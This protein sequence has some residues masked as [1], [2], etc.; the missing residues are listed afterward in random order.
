QGRPLASELRAEPRDG[1]NRKLVAVLAREGADVRGMR[2][3]RSERDV[4]LVPEKLRVRA[5]E[6]EHSPGQVK[7]CAA[8]LDVL[9]QRAGRI[10]PASLFQLGE[11]PS[12][13]GVIDRPPVIG[14]DEREFPQLVS[15]VDVGYSGRSELE[16][17]L[18]E[19]V[20]EAERRKAACERGH[21]VRERIAFASLQTAANELA[22]ARF[23]F[24][25]G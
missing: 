7:F 20:D 8:V 6:L 21:L 1:G 15:L 11:Q 9:E 16:Q 19:P 4:F 17:G 13:Q 25:V 22:Q 2:P 14:I 12:S 23:V 5:A 10:R 3:D 24:L 18:C